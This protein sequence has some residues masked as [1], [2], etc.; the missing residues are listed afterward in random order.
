[1]RRESVRKLI[2]AVMMVMTV[3]L[4]GT[5]AFAAG[6]PKLTKAEG[7]S[8]S[9]KVS[10]TKVKKARG[11]YIYLRKI[12]ETEA[13]RA[14]TVKSASSTSYTVKKL[15]VNTEYVV[16]VTSFDAKGESGKS[17]MKKVRLASKELQAVKD[18]RAIGRDKSILLRWK[19]NSGANGYVIY[20][21]NK[22]GQFEKI[23][24]VKKNKY[25][26]SGL[27]SGE[28]YSFRVASFKTVDGQ[29]VIGV[30]SETVT[31]QA[32]NMKAIKGIHP[33]YYSGTM[34]RTVKSG[35]VTFKAGQKVVVAETSGSTATLVY[36]KKQYKV[37]SGSVST[38]DFVTNNKKR[39]SKELAEQ[40]VNYKGYSS[41]T[42][43]FIWV[44][45]Y[46]QHVY[47]FKGSRNNWKCEKSF[48]CSTG[49]IGTRT[50]LGDG[51]ITG[52]NYVIRWTS[53]Q[54]F[55]YALNKTRGGGWFHSWLYYPSGQLYT[56]V[57]TLGKPA[58]H[59]C[60]R[61]NK[62]DIKWMY[63]HVPTGTK[64]MVW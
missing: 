14:A 29:N 57:G 46:T 5:A 33:Y 60:I 30:P 21:K 3:L 38:H 34:H 16:Y 26:V 20:Q 47:V 54:Y 64:Y 49:R 31:A 22:E 19:K 9:I 37:P 8:T 62:P 41:P 39:P 24:A 55:Y 7:G 45:T 53:M 59:G 32:F 36:K 17:N 63:D 58:S 61:L 48:L 43:Y 28:K 42:N 2:F 50:P 1:M 4:M 12:D 51:T 40:F 35:K 23:K 52:K 18:V 56:G 6:A 10:W 13:K 27:K 15:T 25:L 44:N 11:Y